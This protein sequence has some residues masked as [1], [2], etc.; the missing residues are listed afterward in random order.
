MPASQAVDGLVVSLLHDTLMP[1]DFVTPAVYKLSVAAVG[2]SGVQSQRVVNYIEIA[3]AVSRL[4]DYSLQ[5]SVAG[6]VEPMTLG[7]SPAYNV[8]VP[9]G[10]AAL[11]LQLLP[12][13]PHIRAVHAVFLHSVL[14]D[15]SLA[16]PTCSDAAAA[17][18]GTDS[19]STFS[20][21]AASA[22]ATSES[23]AA[24]SWSRL[25]SC[26]HYSFTLYPVAHAANVLYLQLLTQDFTT[27]HSAVLVRFA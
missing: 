14:A 1:L 25:E 9:H 5:L 23:G 18:A 4:A 19:S 3:P 11:T 27:H 12:V 22:S 24:G 21:A 8:S 6:S 2:T 16:F 13:S 20:G 17:A 10:T 15:L 7:G 26:S